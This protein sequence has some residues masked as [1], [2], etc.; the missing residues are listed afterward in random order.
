MNLYWDIQ[1]HEIL[2]SIQNAQ[3][4]TRLDWILRDQVAVDLYLVQPSTND[5]GYTVQ[6]APTG[7][8]VKFTAKLTSARDGAAYVFQ[9][10]WS[11]SGSGT[12]AKYSGSINLAGATL[13]AGVEAAALYYLD[14]VAE[15]SLQDISGNHRDSTQFDLRVTE[16]VLRASE[17]APAVET[18]PWPWISEYT[19]PTTGKKIVRIKNSDG[20]I[21]AEF[22]PPGV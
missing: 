12:T 10:T 22:A 3:T 7:W 19:D 15:F 2:T 5:T 21:L 11:L 20:E 1:N 13:V 16:D 18:A 17:A 9:G 8:A 14:L 4:L 6:E